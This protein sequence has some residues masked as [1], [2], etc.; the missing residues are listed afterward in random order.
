MKRST[1]I[2]HLVEM[3]TEASDMLRMRDTDIG[4]PLFEMWATG[5]LLDSVAEVESGTVIL[6][7]D[8]APGELPWMARH[9]AGEWVGDRLRLGKRPMLWCYRPSVW[10]AWNARHRQVVRFWSAGDGLDEL[11]IDR[12]RSGAGV[13]AEDPGDEAVRQQLIEERSVG[14]VHLRRIVDSYWDHEWRRNHRGQEAE[15]ALWRA[16]AGLIEID[17]ALASLAP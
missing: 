8:V 14:H 6:L 10:P 9:A 4:W 5:E 17:D 13:A 11:V 15:D 12:L 7:L 16:S 1:A 3:A 2:R